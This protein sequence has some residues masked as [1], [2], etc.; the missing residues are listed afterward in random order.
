[1]VSTVR[2]SLNSLP[3]LNY[4]YWTDSTGVL[5]WIRN[6]KPWR[7]YV[8]HRVNE[9]RALLLQEEWNHC[10]RS[11][12]PANLLSRESKGFDLSQNQHWWNGPEFLCKPKAEWPDTTDFSNIEEAS[13][14]L[15]KDVPV[16]SHSY[17]I[18]STQ[19]RLQN[20][21]NL[22]V[23]TSCYTLLLM[24]SGFQGHCVIPAP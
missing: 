12:N 6:N 19:F 3:H 9:I 14:E 2:K 18:L 5:F 1:L 7:Q 22:A 4:F 13:H 10:P 15:I 23:C 17:A 24:Y 16:I 20:I 11:V 8:A 21:I